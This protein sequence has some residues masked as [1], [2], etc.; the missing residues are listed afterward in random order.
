MSGIN[1]KYITKEEFEGI[2]QEV[3]KDVAR[4][5]ATL[6]LP[7]LDRAIV[8]LDYIAERKGALPQEK[9]KEIA[10]KSAEVGEKG[11]KIIGN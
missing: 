1:N 3:R 2:M 6:L 4:I 11:K 5:S 10:K 7:T 8:L 9:L